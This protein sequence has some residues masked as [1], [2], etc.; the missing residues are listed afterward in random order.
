[1]RLT[2]VATSL[3]ALAAAAAACVVA[4]SLLE[5]PLARGFD[6]ELELVPPARAEEP[7][8][9]VVARV[10]ES[11][12]TVRELERRLSET[13]AGVLAKFGSTDAEIRRNFLEQVVVGDA[14][15]AEEAR[16][17]G[18]DKRRDVRDRTLGALRAMMLFDAA[19]I[20]PDDITDD[21]V[22]EHFEANKAKFAVPK[23]VGIYRILVGS[24]SDAQAILAELGESPDPKKWNDLARDKSLDKSNHLR[25]GNLGFVAEDGSTGQAE[26]RVDPA[27]YKAASA[28]KDGAL[29]P[30][31]VKEGERWAVVWKRQ[32]MNAGS[33]S[34]EVEAPSIRA[35]I[36]DERKRAAVQALLDKLRPELIKELNLELC[37]MVTVTSSGE[38][39]RTQRPGTLPRTKRAATA[40]P[41]EQ[42]PGGLR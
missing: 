15:L 42:Q 8:E 39:E 36:A 19:S 18:L 5:S 1:M 14:L 38:L 24:E 2:R 25:G 3:L 20:K 9:K 26:N 16:A 34:L 6:G 22:R 31:P 11:T 23:R 32:T 21:E 40:T 13:P 7:G 37:D 29:V 17:R 12:I 35:A 4:P 10:G 41:D 33:R 28:V 30:L 27:L